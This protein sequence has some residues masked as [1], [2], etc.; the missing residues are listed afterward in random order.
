MNKRLDTI[1]LLLD[2]GAKSPSMVLQAGVQSANPQIVKIALA[3]KPPVDA[4]SLSMALAAA[5]KANKPEIVELL[6]AA[7][8]APPAAVKTITLDE[9]TVA[10]LRG[11]LSRRPWRH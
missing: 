11:C 5:T 8:A 9:A 1:K 2:N 4:Q 10:D 6:K 7:G 3:A